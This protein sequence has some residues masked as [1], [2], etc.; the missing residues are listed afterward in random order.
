M[1]QH[2]HQK[3]SP[4]NSDSIPSADEIEK[5][6]LGAGATA[7]EL[8]DIMWLADYAA[9]H[10][11][12]NFAALGKAIGVSAATVSKILRGKYAVFDKET[13][14]RLKEI[15]IG[16]FCATIQ[17]FRAQ[18]KEQQDL[19]P[20]VF[21]PKLSVVRR[22]E[23]F[24]EITRATKQIGIMWGKNQSGKTEALKYYAATHPMTA[25]VKL[26]AGGATKP[27]M[28]KL[29]LARGGIPT[30][31][32][33]EELREMIL[34][35]F[36]PLWLPIADEFHQTIKGRAFKTVTI[37]R[38]REVRDDCGCG[39]VI[40][41]T[42]QIPDMMDD[43]RFKDFLGQVG[44]RGVL[45]MFIPTSPTDK[46]IVLLYEAYGF[47]GRPAGDTAAHLKAIANG[48]G[49]GKL[50][51][52]FAMARRLANKEHQAVDWDYFDTT[53]DTLTD[54]AEG[55]FEEER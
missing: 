7:E 33:Y 28:K 8:E 14:E 39:L 42:D 44:N 19:G 2:Q 3:P 17:N 10:N 51:C 25:Y 46:D 53:Y 22:V 50:S 29:A 36:N 40:C 47:K 26:P 9:T 4:D 23:Q 54:W 49:I 52:Y 43:E 15:G 34:K 21:V 38:F 5:A 24:C 32:S 13:K 6:V 30:R 55:K 45:R 1:Q 41:G 11:L 18:A 12:T 48:N 16:S 20:L 37:D 27:S 31:K 35:R